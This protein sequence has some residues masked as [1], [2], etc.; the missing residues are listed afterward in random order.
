MSSFWFLSFLMLIYPFSLEHMFL[1]KI[2]VY[3]DKKQQQ[4]NEIYLSP[5]CIYRNDPLSVILTSCFSGHDQELTEVRAHPSQ[6][7]VMT[8][9]KDTTFRLW[10]F[11][12]ANMP[13]TV[14]QG[15]SQYVYFYIILNPLMPTGVFYLLIW[16]DPCSIEG[17][18]GYYDLI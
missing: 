14:F 5:N 4:K 7:L 12:D 15:H 13:V 17:V 3:R 6:S 18:F 10:D 11:R 1:W 16:A 8:S 9:S 2:Y